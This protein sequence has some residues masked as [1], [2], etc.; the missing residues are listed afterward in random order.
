M[1]ETIRAAFRS[2]AGWCRR[3]GAP[4]TAGICDAAAIGLDR[5][6]AVGRRVLDWEG[7]PVA[8]A[9][10]LRLTGGLNALVR[11][12]FLPELG[13]FYPPGDR[14]IPPGVMARALAD[15]RLLPW[16]DAAPQTNEVARSG[17]L[18]PGLLVVA[19]ATHLPLALFE[20]GASAGLN[21][22]L[23]RYAYRLGGYDTGPS[24]APL[25][26]TPEWHGPPPPAAAIRVT[27][28]RGVDLSPIDL[29]APTA[30]ERLLA[31]VWP[32][33]VARVTRLE[34]AIAAFVADPVALDRADA[35]DWVDA[36]V[37]TA[38]G[39]ATV[40]FHSIAWQYFPAATRARIAARLADVGAAAT[41]D[42]PLAWF[43]F[44]LDALAAA[45][46]LR[47]TTWPGGE[48]RLLANAG[49][50]GASVTW[51]G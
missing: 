34:A 24:G 44:E 27:S 35:A 22:R 14:P 4:F 50:H 38:S 36:Q 49:P 2:Q 21:L 46:A 17:V 40:V 20:L 19:A 9:V 25:T 3:L 23:D 18:M 8:D 45:P 30:R 26:L 28:R 51:Y 5:S 39:V 29:T 48:D 6:G 10:A 1:D 41:V 42:A 33:Q 32:E 47:L 7:D 15:D 12:G 11:G 43:R 31:Y 16:L 13:A 37:A